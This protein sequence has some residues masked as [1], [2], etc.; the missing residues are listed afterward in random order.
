MVVSAQGALD[1][2]SD[3]PVVSDGGGQGEQAGGDAGADTSE[4]APAVVFESELAFECAGDR[5]AGGVQ[6][7]LAKTPP[8]SP[9]A[10]GEGDAAAEATECNNPNAFIYLRQ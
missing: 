6:T 7:V 10:A 5:L 8:P 3:V 2:C 1:G 9:D 4:G